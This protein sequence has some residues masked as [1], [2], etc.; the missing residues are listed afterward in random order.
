MTKWHW[1]PDKNLANK[2]K[3]GLTFE[4]ARLVFL[5]Q[6]AL[7]VPDP[8]RDEPRWRTIGMIG[9]QTVLVVHTEP[10]LVGEGV[11]AG[12]IISAR[13][14]TRKERRYYEADQP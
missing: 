8:Y 12:R 9:S 7:S 11:E 4:T 6:M 3:H 14:A 2:R 13:K 10:A 5:D 1:D